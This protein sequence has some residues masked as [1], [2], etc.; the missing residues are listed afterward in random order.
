MIPYGNCWASRKFANGSAAEVMLDLPHLEV[1]IKTVA[2]VG[3]AGVMLW[4]SSSFVNTQAKCAE[5]QAYVNQTLGPLVKSTLGTATSC[6]AQ[7]CSS[8]GRCNTFQPPT[9]DP[10]GRYAQLAG[11]FQGCRCYP[12]VSGET[13]EG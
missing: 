4:G 6:S 3:A 1:Q 5:I 7:Q 10:P 8:K 11:S 13:C 9:P 12:G 2:E